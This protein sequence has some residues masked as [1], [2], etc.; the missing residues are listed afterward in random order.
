MTETK[1]QYRWWELPV[2][3]AIALRD[4]YAG[5]I[6]DKRHQIQELEL[7]RN[8][9]RYAEAVTLVEESVK[10]PAKPNPLTGKPWAITPALEYVDHTREAE[11]EDRHLLLWRGEL[12]K[13]E[14]DLRLV[15]QWIRWET[16]LVG[17]GGRVP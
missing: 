11:D 17:A 1:A 15:D 2:P 14:D 7:N 9:R 10:D 13:L 16:T 6:R 12:A 8:L 3:E 4:R 5:L